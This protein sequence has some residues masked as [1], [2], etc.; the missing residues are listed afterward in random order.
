MNKPNRLHSKLMA[1]DEVEGSLLSLDTPEK[2]LW[3][4]VLYRAIKD[5]LMLKHGFYAITDNRNYKIAGG[6]PTCKKLKE[7]KEWF[8][9]NCKEPCSFLWIID[10]IATDSDHFKQKIREYI[11]SDLE[12]IRR[13]V[14][15][16]NKRSKRRVA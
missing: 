16:I 12:V 6:R 7:I 4:W 15:F 13:D 5:Y 3:Y 11:E 9:S 14:G 1:L 10:N 8:D 2:C